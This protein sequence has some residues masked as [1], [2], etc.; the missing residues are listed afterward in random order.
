[1]QVFVNTHLQIT[2]LMN[3]YE[4]ERRKDE[5][6]VRRWC[7]M[8]FRRRSSNVRAPNLRYP[9]RGRRPFEAVLR[10]C[11]VGKCRNR[12]QFRESCPNVRSELEGPSTWFGN[13]CPFLEITGKGIY[14]RGWNFTLSRKGTYGILCLPEELAPEHPWP[15][16]R[17]S[18]CRICTVGW[19]LNP[20]RLEPFLRSSKVDHMIPVHRIHTPK[21][22]K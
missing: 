12:L 10:P 4:F 1:M 8:P 22:I 13:P 15:K 16:H 9:L 5:S 7:D 21:N 14:Q 6:C 18:G 2:Y 17:W 11:N 19:P 3:A 20:V